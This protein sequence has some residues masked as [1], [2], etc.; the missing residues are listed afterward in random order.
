M[1]YAMKKVNGALEAAIGKGVMVI[2]STREWSNIPACQERG[3]SNP[4]MYDP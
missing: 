2:E 3:S 4:P 1:S